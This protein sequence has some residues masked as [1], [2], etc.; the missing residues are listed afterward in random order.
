[1]KLQLQLLTA[2]YQINFTKTFVC[3]GNET[4]IVLLHDVL[5]VPITTQKGSRTL[6]FHNYII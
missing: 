6:E 3:M 5:H 1:M 2:S 4:A